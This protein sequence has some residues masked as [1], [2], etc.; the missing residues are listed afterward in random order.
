M[1]RIKLEMPERFRFST[2]L[3]VRIGDI[4]Y[5]GHLGNDAV[6]TLA[7][8]ARIRFLAAFGYSEMDVEGYGIIMSDAAVVYRSEA[9]RPDRLRIEAEPADFGRFGFD[10]FYRI[11]RIETAA[12]IALVKTGIAF[13]DYAA[14]KIVPMP[15]GFIATMQR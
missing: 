9:F 8:E 13:F 11:T 14:R 5:G 2:E 6:L 4:N 7:H 12:E 10:L 3:T 1:G 15:T